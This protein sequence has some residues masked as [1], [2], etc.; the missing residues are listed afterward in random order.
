M[1]VGFSLGHENVPGTGLVV[2][3]A[4]GYFVLASLATTWE[5]VRA[6]TALTVAWGTHA[7]V[8]LSHASGLLPA[9]IVPGWYPPVCATYDVL[10]AALCCLPVLRR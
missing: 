5:P 3:I 10:V 2:A 4:A 8:D 7:V 9:E 6:L 1:P